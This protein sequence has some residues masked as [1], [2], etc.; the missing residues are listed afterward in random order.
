MEKEILRLDDK[1]YT[2]QKKMMD[3]D[4][5]INSVLRTIN[6]NTSVSLIKSKNDQVMRYRKEMLGFATSI[7]NLE[8]QKRS[9]KETLIKKKETLRKAELAE[10][11]K[12]LQGNRSVKYSPVK[13]FDSGTGASTFEIEEE[14]MGETEDVVSSEPGAIQVFVSYSW[15]TKEHEEKVFDFVNHLRTP[16]GFDAH[17]DK[18]LSQKET[19]IDFVKMMYQAMHNFPKIVVI[20]SKGFKNKADGFSGGVGTEYELMIN[21]INDHPNKYILASFGGRDNSIIP[22]GF[23]GRDIVDLSNPDGMTQLYEKL[24]D[25]QG[26]VFAEVAKVTRELPIR[27]AR[28]FSATD[29]VAAAALTEAISIT[30]I[31]KPTGDSGLAAGKY[32]D[33]SFNLKFEFLNTTAGTIEGFSYIIKL[34]KELDLNHYLDADHE[35]Y[36]IYQHSHEGK[37]YRGQRVQTVGFLLRVEHQNIL[38]IMDA[39]IKVEV[40]NEHGPV[41]REFPAKELIK[42]HP[43]GESYAE[44]VPI[45]PDLFKS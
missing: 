20:L 24:L 42:I 14:F 41:E 33:I 13:R 10:Q 6:K 9:K 3:R 34:P 5:K 31:I 2:E 21:D 37:M 27:V 18:G 36:V 28:P 8:K 11:K 43:G 38:K 44:A 26:Y 25:H 22:Y 45:S 23:K 12:E 1:I 39:I 32:K 4:A 35:G 19:S 30:P 16:G 17:M 15:D 40:F 29:V 7:N